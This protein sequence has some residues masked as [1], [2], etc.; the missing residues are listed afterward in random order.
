[1]LAYGGS[2]LGYT[3]ASRHLF[4]FLYKLGDIEYPPPKHAYH[5]DYNSNWIRYSSSVQKEIPNLEQET[6]RLI[7]VQAKSGE[8]RGHVKTDR[9]G[10]WPD[11]E[12]ERDLYYAMNIFIL[13]VEADYQVKGCYE[14][15]VEPTYRFW[16]AYDWH[17][18]LKAGGAVGGLAGFKDDWAAALQDAGLAAAFEIRGYWE[19]PN[20]VYVFPPSWLTLN[21]PPP[22]ISIRTDWQRQ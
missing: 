9:V 1:M 19:G 16:D 17:P 5:R 3:H 4:Q 20:K 21:V 14:A 13:W 8:M 18:G 11:P 6:L 12:S 2:I 22:P 7:H 10:I 15:T